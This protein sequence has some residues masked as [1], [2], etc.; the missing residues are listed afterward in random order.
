LNH[1]FSCSLKHWQRISILIGLLVTGL[2]GLYII[3]P[4]PQDP[5]YHLFADVRSLFGIP[6]FND[7]I[8]K[9]GFFIVGFIGILTATPATFLL[10]G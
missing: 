4:I 1:D 8:S 2:L 5:G 3:E 7:V 9:A 10:A 6:N